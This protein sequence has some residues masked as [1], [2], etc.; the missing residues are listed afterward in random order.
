MKFGYT[1]LGYPLFKLGAKIPKG[2]LQKKFLT[3][4]ENEIPFLYL[5]IH[6]DH[7]CRISLGTMAFSLETQFLFD[8]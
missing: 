1:N 3:G 5:C 2:I 7:C 6:L 4:W 8:Y